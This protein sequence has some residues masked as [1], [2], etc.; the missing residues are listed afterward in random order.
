ME[1]KVPENLENPI[2]NMI[3]KDME[4]VGKFFKENNFTPNMLTTI[5]AFFGLLSIYAICKNKFIV[6]G[7]LY[8]ISYYFDC[9]DGYYARKYNMVTKFGD[10]YD[11]V[12]DIVVFMGLI[13]VLIYKK[14]HIGL[15]FI[16]P[17]FFL[18][19]VHFGC[20]EVY[21]EHNES[22]T[23]DFTRYLCPT[24][25]KK[26]LEKIMK[27]TRYFGCGTVILIFCLYLISVQ[28]TKS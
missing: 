14:L 21:Y 24:D 6:A 13:F 15:L 7:I 18:M 28:L 19:L 8:F 16:I 11:H 4:N 9:L 26:E 5:S 3:Y 10:Y 12:K 27:Y 25:D 20:Q 17:F 22:D 2:D 23:L 1:R